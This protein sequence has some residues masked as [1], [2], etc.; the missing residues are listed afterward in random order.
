M[1]IHFAGNDFLLSK[2]SEKGGVAM[3]SFKII[4]QSCGEECEI[5]DFIDFG[6]QGTSQIRISH[7]LEICG[8]EI[9]GDFKINCFECGNN[10]YLPH[11]DIY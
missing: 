1:F 6:Q 9:T 10:S 2:I 7:D 5:E 8:D 4:C 3:S 11:K